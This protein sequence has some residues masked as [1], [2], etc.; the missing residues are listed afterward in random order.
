MAVLGSS[1][2]IASFYCRRKNKCSL[3]EEF[4]DFS[5]SPFPDVV[6]DLQVKDVLLEVMKRIYGARRQQIYGIFVM[7]VGAFL[8]F[9]VLLPLSVW[10]YNNSSTSTGT[11]SAPTATTT[12]PTAT[13]HKNATA[14]AT[15]AANATTD[16]DNAFWMDSFLWLFFLFIIMCIM[17]LVCLYGWRFKATRKR[18]AIIKEFNG[19]SK[20]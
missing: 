18:A 12:A 17:S 15:N 5:S 6:A 1:I 3:T 4:G 16:K 13:G 8:V 14:N 11:E 19:K 7:L 9:A 20:Y 10:S 2:P